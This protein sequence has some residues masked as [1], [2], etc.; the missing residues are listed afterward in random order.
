MSAPDTDE[1]PTTSA[2]QAAD[3]AALEAMALG[4]IQTPGAPP[5]PQGP[6]APSAE[7]MGVAAMV[8]GVAQ[9]LLMATV[10]GLN[11]APIELW[12]PVTV[13]VAGL[14]EHYGLARPEL[15]GPW[16]RLAV[17]VVP[18]AGMAMLAQMQEPEK[19]P[20]KSSV[21]QVPGQLPEKLPEP[22]AEA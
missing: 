22:E 20:E 21:Y 12:E 19:Q 11:T 17:S 10:R 14:L 18:L 3:L 7:A 8:M 15:Q 16:A 2:E 4:Q 9:P 13:S 1:G 5:A 6:P